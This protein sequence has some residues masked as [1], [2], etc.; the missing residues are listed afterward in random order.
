MQ[1]W[2]GIVRSQGKEKKAEFCLKGGLAEKKGGDHPPGRIS[3][4]WLMAGMAAIHASASKV[5]SFF[6]SL[7]RTFI[8]RFA[9]N[10]ERAKHHEENK[11]KGRVG[12]RDPEKVMRPD[13]QQML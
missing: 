10:N 1:L 8:H 9:G 3:I 7:D 13:E 12:E 4:S 11:N 6:P 2:L 5:F